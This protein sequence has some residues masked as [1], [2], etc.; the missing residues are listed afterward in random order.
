VRESLSL[1]PSWY[2]RLGDI[3]APEIKDHF[4]SYRNIK[5][6]AAWG[7]TAADFDDCLPNDWVVDESFSL[8]ENL[9]QGYRP[10][11]IAR[12]RRKFR[13]EESD[14]GEPTQYTSTLIEAKINTD[15][16]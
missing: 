8:G 3:A 16:K 5:A 12:Y 6:D 1:D 10:R 13:L 7:A 4:G 15:L 11:G 2:F 14:R 9:S